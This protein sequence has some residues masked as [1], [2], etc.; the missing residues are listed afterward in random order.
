[1]AASKNSAGRKPL[2]LH[3]R[4][5]AVLLSLALLPVGAA[6]QS[7][8]PKAPLIE[9]GSTRAPTAPVHFVSRTVSGTSNS[10]SA[11][12]DRL[13]SIKV[14]L[15]ALGAGIM[16]FWKAHGLDDKY[17]GIHGM[18]DREGKPGQD[19]DKGLVQQT[20]H[21]WSFSAW[22]ERREQTPQIKAVADNIYQFLVTRFLDRADG[23]FYY[24]VSRDG[25]RVVD[26]KKQLYAES[27][28]IF[29]LSKYSE[30]FDVAEAGQQAMACFKS[31]D[32]RAHDAE[33]QGY[34]QSQDPG[35]LAPGAQK[36]TN[37]HIHLLESFTALYRLSKDETVRA[38]LSELV[39]VI[40]T[41]IVQPSNYAHKEF[42]K[43]WRV[44]EKPVVSYGHDLETAWLLVDALDALGTPLEPMVSQ[45]AL[46]L[47]KH[48]AE[49]GY[50]P[51]LGGYFEEGMPG[52]A[53]TKL[54][55]IWWIQ[56]EALPGLWWL[57][58]LESSASY[59]D[60]L[61]GTLAWIESKQLD[62]EHGEWFWGINPDGSIGPRGAHKG[63]E[64]KAQ[65]HGLRAVL[66]VADWIDQVLSRAPGGSPPKSAE[67]TGTTAANA[68]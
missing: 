7:P 60:R 64:W 20:R 19:A 12:D 51:S 32:R 22:Y 3:G 46:Q 28:A 38:R 17:G 23:E 4:A 65:Y 44:H 24:K 18:H 52:G 67:R 34:D 53:P 35:W 31:I 30:V 49:R 63:E 13:G 58:R 42:F 1:M 59:L 26:P 36:D 57:Y 9:E 6:C 66:F 48:S 39:K 8:L 47:G 15:D 56:A 50:D 10:E 25:T 41:R 55:K 43:D 14:R 62:R 33:H 37:T 16:D 21:L 54:E 5:A 2:N 68:P 45:V 29:A 61:E 40:A 11:A 27:F